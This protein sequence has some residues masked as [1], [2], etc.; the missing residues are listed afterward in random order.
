MKNKGKVR[1]P[2][3]WLG[4]GLL[5][6]VL[7]FTLVPRIK[8]IVELS[9]RKQALLEQKAELEKE[10]QALQL[11]LEQADSPENIERIAREQ[12]GMVRPGEQPLIP[13]LSR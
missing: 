1:Q 9:E 5:C 11:E 12:L 10:Q 7:L 6:T 13:V 4:I 3:R 2:L 8:T